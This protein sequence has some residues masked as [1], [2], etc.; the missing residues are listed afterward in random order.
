VPEISDQ[1][2]IVRS[3]EIQGWKTSVS[4][5]CLSGREHLHQLI[6]FFASGLEVLC[7]PQ[8]L[9]FVST[10]LIPDFPA[11]YPHQETASEPQFRVDF[12]WCDP[13]N[14]SCKH[15]IWEDTKNGIQFLAT[16]TCT[17][18]PKSFNTSIML[19]NGG[20]VALKQTPVPVPKGYKTWKTSHKRKV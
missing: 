4:V 18:K 2:Q 10:Y 7:G 17:L 5:L 13:E 19:S 11:V 1:H 16:K 14:E 20:F 9:H 8:I 3:I 12:W 6:R 15:R